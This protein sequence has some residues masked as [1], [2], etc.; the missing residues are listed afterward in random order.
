MNDDTVLAIPVK[1]LQNWL[2][3]L[4]SAV[5]P[6]VPFDYDNTKMLANAYEYRGGVLHVIANQLRARGVENK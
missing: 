3:Q 4:D 1:E 2:K 6:T 5:R